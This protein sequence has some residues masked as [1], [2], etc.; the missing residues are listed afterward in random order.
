MGGQVSDRDGLQLR[1]RAELARSPKVW[2]GIPHHDDT[3]TVELQ[4]PVVDSAVTSGVARAFGESE[5]LH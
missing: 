2:A 4:F 5:G 3:A 1:Y